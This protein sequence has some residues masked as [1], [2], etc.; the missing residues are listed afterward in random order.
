MKILRKYSG[1]LGVLNKLW[2]NFQKISKK[3][4]KFNEIQTYKEKFSICR[5]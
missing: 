2:E 5:K 1:K 3:L 4:E